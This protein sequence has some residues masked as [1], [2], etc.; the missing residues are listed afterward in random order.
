ELCSRLDLGGNVFV[1][2]ALDWELQNQYQIAVSAL[3]A[4]NVLYSDPLHITITVED[5]NDNVP[6][7]PRDTYLVQVTEAAGKDFLLLELKAED[8]DDP[9]TMNAQIRYKIESQE[10]QLPS[11]HLFHIGETTGHLTLLSDGLKIADAKNYTLV[12]SATDLAGAEGGLSSTCTVIIDVLDINDNPPVFIQNQFP[13]FVIRE[14]TMPDTI[15]VTLT[16]VDEDV[17]MENRATE[18]SVLS[19]NEDETFGIKPNEEQNTVTVFLQKA[20]DY[21]LAQEYSLVIEARNKV[22]LVGTEYGSSS[23]A[24]IVIMVTDVNEAP[25]FTQKTYEVQVSENASVESV[26]LTVEAS[27]PDIYNKTRLRYSIRNDIRNWLSIQEESGKIQLLRPLDREQRDSTYNVQV[28]AEEIGDGGLSSSAD[29]LIHF[30]N[31]DVNDNAPILVADYTYTYFCTPRREEQKVIIQAYVRDSPKNSA[32]FRFSLPND[33]ALEKYWMVTIINGT[34]AYLSMRSHYLEP[35][36]HQVPVIITNTGAKPQ[37]KH[38]PITGMSI[39]VLIPLSHEISS[40]SE[41]FFTSK[42]AKE[43]PDSYNFNVW[44]TEYH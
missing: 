38:V 23:S 17:E 33:A 9:S 27:D 8:L 43:Y 13:P 26:I 14:D 25:V 36:V 42:E 37:S 31:L 40:A 7:F 2:R 19:G 39:N 32:P 34:H 18:F 15:I 5:E 10:P 44:I 28:V 20:L 12:I 4:E 24:S 16:V 30:L 6:L 21:E 41:G 1:T 29:V 35:R 3:N 11:D 22:D